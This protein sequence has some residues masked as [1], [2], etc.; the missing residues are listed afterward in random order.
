M[1][2]KLIILF[3]LINLPFMEAQ[4]SMLV[5]SFEV[6]TQLNW[7]IINDGVMGGISD[8]ELQILPTGVGEFRGNVS[9]ENNGGFAST[10]GLLTRLP[11]EA[12]TKIKLRVRG[13]GKKYSFRIRTDGQYDG[14]SYKN[15]F[16]TKAG[17]WEEITLRLADFKP[18]WRGRTLTNIPPIEPTQIRQIGFL[19]S[20]KQEG[21][22][23]LLID[24]IKL[25]D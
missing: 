7:R 10:R 3:L 4:S 17:D 24:W 20:N 16:E 23:T 8:S 18:T 12:Y 15:D 25:L 2:D 11:S 13:D 21:A 22:F 5:E 14:V 19:I 6:P 9:L 1:I